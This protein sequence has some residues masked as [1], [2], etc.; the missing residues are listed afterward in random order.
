MGPKPGPTMRA[1][2]SL[3]VVLLALLGAVRPAWAEEVFVLENGVVL[4]GTAMRESGDEVVIRLSGF[5]EDAR[6]TVATTQIVRRHAGSTGVP[7]RP[8]GAP[9]L[10]YTDA[11]LAEADP[12]PRFA[13]RP[14]AAPSGEL[15]PLEEPSLQREGFF[16]RLGRVAHMATPEDPVT[17][18]VLAGLFGIALLALVGLGGRL[19][20]FE[21]LRLGHA[22]LL[23]AGL[24]AALLAD[25]A[26]ADILLRADRATWVLPAQALAWVGLAWGSLRCGPGRA[27]LLLAFLLFS[28]G[29]VGFAAGAVL[30][31]F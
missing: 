16:A 27:V 9:A 12:L 10:G 7:R 17:R 4:R 24:G 21:D 14:W 15:L 6:V 20:E 8:A 23:A 11:P 26:H 25:V 22:A 28:L 30:V 31:A 19:L 3:A 2:L 29:V 1:L 18:L 13:G 5:P